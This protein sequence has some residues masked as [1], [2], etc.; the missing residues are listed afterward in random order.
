LPSRLSIRRLDPESAPRATKADVRRLV[1]ERLPGFLRYW[2]T[3]QS[4]FL[5]G[6]ARNTAAGPFP[7]EGGWAV[8]AGAHF[9]LSPDEVAV[10]TIAPGKALSVSIQLNDVWMISPDATRHQSSLNPS[11]FVKGSDDLVTC[12]VS[13]IDPGITNWLDSAGLRDGYLIIRWFGISAGD[14]LLREFKVIPR[15]Q[16][17]SPEFASLPRT[18]PTRRKQDIA[19]RARE[20][21]TRLS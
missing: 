21:T 2:A 17:A 18:S 13:P 20:Y 15:A 4:R 10:L 9:S 1:L 14:S 3:Y 19:R 12:V 7:R 5:G 8:L 6:V 16:L 11:Q